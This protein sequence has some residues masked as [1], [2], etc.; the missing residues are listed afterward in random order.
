MKKRHEVQKFLNKLL[1][2]EKGAMLVGNDYSEHD[3]YRDSSVFFKRAFGGKHG[4]IKYLEN[5]PVQE[6]RRPPKLNMDV[7]TRSIDDLEK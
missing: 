7:R 6:R 2:G 1:S 3:A 5:E 4:E